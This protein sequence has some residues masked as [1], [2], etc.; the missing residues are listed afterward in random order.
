MHNV[1]PEITIDMEMTEIV[2]E[3]GTAAE[4]FIVVAETAF[5][6]KLFGKHILN[7]H[8]FLVK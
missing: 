3:A 5:T 2:F 1:S 8:F 7:L 4:V 6:E